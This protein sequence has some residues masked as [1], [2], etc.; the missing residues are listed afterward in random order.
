MSSQ[1]SSQPR[2]LVV[3][4]SPGRFSANEKQDIAPYMHAVESWVFATNGDYISFRDVQARDIQGYDIVIVNTSA[5]NEPAV[6][7][8]FRL[9]AENRP[10][11][12]RWMTMLE[13]DMLAYLKPHEHLAE[14][15]NA[16]DVVNCINI[17]ALPL[18]K[19]MT[20]TRVE[21]LGIPVPYQGIR[22]FSTPLAQRKRE[23]LICPMVMNRWNDYFAMSRL[24]IPLHGYVRTMSRK[25]KNTWQNWKEHGA[26]LD[27]QATVKHA[28]RLYPNPP[29]TIHTEK[30][31]SGFYQQAGSLYF[32]MNLDERHTWGRFVLEAAALQIPIITTRATGHGERLF[33]RT[34]V[35]HAFDID[36]ANAVAQQL[37]DDPDFYR[38]VV[39]DSQQGLEEFAPERM[40]EKLFHL[41]GVR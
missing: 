24:G 6:S 1:L 32:W 40:K 16:S 39:E 7:H 2:V 22:A 31:F 36:N 29:I 12:C 28:Q 18:F 14:V 11:G 37:L 15:F 9:L 23:A 17:H 20:Q 10:S 21:F 38:A 33:P 13:G 3:G 30:W 8:H 19:A 26:I 27:K 5:F 35:A 41:L 34:T 4:G 25:L